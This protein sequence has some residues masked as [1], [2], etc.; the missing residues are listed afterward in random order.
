M[1]AL[2]AAPGSAGLAPGIVEPPWRRTSSSRPVAERV[3]H[4]LFARC[5]ERL[6]N[7]SEAR[8]GAE[9]RRRLLAGRS[10]R[11]IE[12]GAGSG[13]NF[14]HYPSTVSEVLAIEPEGYLRGRAQDAAARA[15]V[16][17]AVADGLAESLPC[18]T[19]S[20]DV[21]VASLVLCTVPDQRRALA[22]LFRAIRPGGEL[23][24]YEHVLAHTPGEA[25]VQRLADATFWPRIAGGCH[26]ARDTS[27][28]IEQAGFAI[29]RC[30]RFAFSP[31]R[32][33]PPAAHLLGVAR[34]P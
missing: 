33:L 5:Y 3:H 7:I 1:L 27:A 14:A 6:A 21:G 24:F 31:A 10:G 4:P 32:Y 26:L 18:E 12:M 30:E 28:A 34:R 29:E 17:I 20:F 8:G 11:V 22:E 9:H 25:R 16:A 13:A 19:G 15:P 2:S 23:R